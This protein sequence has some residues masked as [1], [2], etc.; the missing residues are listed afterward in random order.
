ML[1]Y[2]ENYRNEIRFVRGFSIGGKKLKSTIGWDG[3]P[4]G[5]NRSGFDALPAGFFLVG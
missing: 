3:H 4:D 5:N 1:T 2:K